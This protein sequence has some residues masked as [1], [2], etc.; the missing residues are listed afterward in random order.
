MITTK[1][2]FS[3]KLK[4]MSIGLAI[5]I[6][7]I[8]AANATEIESEHGHPKNAIGLFL[9]ATH[10]HGENEPTAGL[11]IG[12]NLNEDWSAGLM[13]EQTDRG[14]ETS[15]ILAGVGWHPSK[16][17]RMQLAVG[18]K[19]PSGKHENVLRT[20]LAY[21]YEIGHN[22]FIKPYLAYDFI[23]HEEDEPVFGFYIVRMF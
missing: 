9:G 5:A 19:N 20:A 8:G 18:R 13:F 10:A 16:W 7:S 15:L 3:D 17:V 14:K 2:N 23:E 4:W 6:A 21:E 1:Y 12:R 22:W 11:E